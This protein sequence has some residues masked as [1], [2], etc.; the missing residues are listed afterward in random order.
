[1]HTRR[2]SGDR[3]QRPSTFSAPV[4]RRLGATAFLSTGAVAP[5]MSGFGSSDTKLAGG[6]G[7]RYPLSRSEG[8]NVRV[9]FGYG[10]G[11]SGTYITLG[12]AF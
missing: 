5:R 2:A 9:D 4:W 1:M 6:W 12:E 3:A 10:E 7:I 11:S 8:L